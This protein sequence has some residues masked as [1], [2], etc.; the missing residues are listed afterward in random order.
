MTIKELRDFIYENYYRQIG[1]SKKKQ[2]LFSQTL[3][4]KHLLLLAS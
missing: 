4:Q 2:L 3:E 1:F